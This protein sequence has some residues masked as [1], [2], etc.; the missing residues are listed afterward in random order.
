MT[1]PRRTYPISEDLYPDK[2]PQELLREYAEEFAQNLL[3]SAD[4]EVFMANLPPEALAELDEDELDEAFDLVAHGEAVLADIA[5][6]GQRAG[7]WTPS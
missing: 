6:E 5:I 2:T 7:R 1:E 4:F 3:E